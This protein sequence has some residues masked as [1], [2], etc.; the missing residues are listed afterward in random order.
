MKFT[1]TLTA[2]GIDMEKYRRTLDRHL[3]EA[4][5]QA[6]VQW[7]EATVLAEV[8][9]WSGASRATF[10]ALAR[11]VEYNIPIFP[12]APSRIGRGIAESSGSLETD[13]ARGR[14]VFQYRTTLPWLIINEYFDATQWG[15]HLKKPGPY[16]FQEKGKAAFRKFAEGVRLPNPFECLKSTKIKVR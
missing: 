7:L 4:L 6:I 10:L 16:D 8:P 14:Y 12:A 11:N 9:V 15:F 2:L 3:R 1:G 5:A 13:E